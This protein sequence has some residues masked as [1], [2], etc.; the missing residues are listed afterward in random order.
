M[1]IIVNKKTLSIPEDYKVID[2]LK[3]LN[4]GKNVAVFVDKK[5]LLLSEYENTRIEEK[6][7]I[8]IIRPLGGG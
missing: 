2:L 6:N 8:R 4:Y 5:Q 1:E 3:Y 7:N